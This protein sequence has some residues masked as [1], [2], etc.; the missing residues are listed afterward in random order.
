MEEEYTGPK[1]R[2]AGAAR[3]SAAA[4]VAPRTRESLLVSAVAMPLL[5][6][7][8]MPMQLQLLSQHR[9]QRQQGGGASWAF[10]LHLLQLRHRTYKEMLAHEPS[11]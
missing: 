6:S 9:S 5:V 1:T 11:A 4:T 2:Q 3:P 10:A 8:G 7:G